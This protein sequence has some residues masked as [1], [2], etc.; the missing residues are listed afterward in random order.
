MVSIE[1]GP[2]ADRPRRIL[3]VDDDESR[4]E[5]FAKVMAHEGYEVDTLAHGRNLMA[6]VRAKP[7]DLVLLDIMLPEISG[8][9]LCGDL[10]MMEDTRL[11]PI[12]LI[13]SAFPDEESVV[14][15][16][17][18]GADD[19]VVTPSRLDEVRARVRVQL[20]NRRDREVLQWA[21]AQASSLKT[22]ALSDVL[23]GLANRRA[24]DEVLEEALRAGE[25][26]LAVLLDIDHFKQFNDTFGH[27]TGDLVLGQV[28]RA[29]T[30]ST[31]SG[32][33]AA[34]YGGEEFLVIV[35]GASLDAAARIGERYR[36][37]IANIDLALTANKQ[38]PGAEEEPRAKNVTVSIGV[39]ASSR[40][41]LSNPAALLA[42]A[43]EALYKAKVEG[44]NRV[45]VHT[46][47]SR[48]D[49][50]GKPADDSN[51]DGSGERR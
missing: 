22:A 37:A 27:A 29:I 32:D 34:R 26:V 48:A 41:S 33:T 12:I 25:R 28:A 39:A 45:V 24:A 47:E 17:L 36:R 23:T 10:R 21:K 49:E 15:G 43:D 6:Q 50:R 20:R 4:R 11:T 40:E 3:I 18:S 5:L 7:P 30:A 46:P 14:R 31:R 38:R 8:F 44:R 35:R 9:E 42:A 16:L 19:Y 13:T 51:T 1:S 2:P